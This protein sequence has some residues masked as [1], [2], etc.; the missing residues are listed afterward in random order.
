M[1]KIMLIEDDRTM[2]LLLSTLMQM[3]GFEVCSS[4]DDSPEALLATI[5]RECPDVTILDVYLRQGSGLD[6]IK[7]IRADADLQGLRVLMTSGL[8]FK[9]EC[10]EAGAND[11]L[12]KPYMPD[13]L[14][15]SIKNLIGIN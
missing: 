14:I 11:F 3:E 6:L 12:L 15:K 1:P 8:D 5:R 10:L 13:D 9:V 2:L 4:Q 7:S